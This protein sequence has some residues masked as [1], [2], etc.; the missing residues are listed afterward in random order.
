ME[1][2]VFRLEAHWEPNT[3]NN[4]IQT[5][6][7][8]QWEN[9]EHPEKKVTCKHHK[10]ISISLKLYDNEEIVSNFEVKLLLP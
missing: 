4:V 5:P 7:T 10:S 9:S 3:L 8:H 2:Y 6:H 1:G